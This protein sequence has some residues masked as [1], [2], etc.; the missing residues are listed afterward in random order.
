MMANLLRHAKV[1]QN[2]AARGIAEPDGPC[3]AARWMCTAQGEY[4]T[5]LQCRVVT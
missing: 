2:W 5:R 4:A 1:R 3:P